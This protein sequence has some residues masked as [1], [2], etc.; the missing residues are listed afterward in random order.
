MYLPDEKQFM[1]DFGP[2][3]IK[4]TD[5]I[6][7]EQY[8]YY[9]GEEVSQYVYKIEENS[10]KKYESVFEVNDEEIFSIKIDRV[11]DKYEVK[12]GYMTYSGKISTKNKETTITLDKITEDNEWYGSSSTIKTDLT[13]VIDQK[14]KMPSAPKNYDSI[15]DIEV[16]DIEKWEEKLEGSFELDGYCYDCYSNGAN[17]EWNGHHYCYDCYMDIIMGDLWD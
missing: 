4:D 11:K 2:K 1:L 5:Q 12:S 15:A 17:Y 8:S 16:K 10:K 3:G 6:T 13:I 9:Y 7:M 14:D